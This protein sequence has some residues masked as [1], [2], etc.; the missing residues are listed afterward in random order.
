MPEEVLS[1][2]TN[3]TKEKKRDKTKPSIISKQELDKQLL[4]AVKK[5]DDLWKGGTT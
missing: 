5:V 1:K 4:G 3:N 2:D